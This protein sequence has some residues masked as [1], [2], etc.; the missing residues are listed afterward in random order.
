MDGAASREGY[1]TPPAARFKGP[2]RAPP[3]PP[4]I[5]TVVAMASSFTVKAKYQTQTR[6]FAF[7]GS[8][9]FPTFSDLQREVCCKSCSSSSLS[10]ISRLSSSC[11]S[12]PN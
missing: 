8:Y 1:V 7:Q 5:L 3:S 6:K 10:L 12:S 9:S 4:V 11:A 2:G